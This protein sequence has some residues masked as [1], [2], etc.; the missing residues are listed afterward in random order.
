MDDCEIRLGLPI[1][2]RMSWTARR[3]TTREEAVAYRLL[4]IFDINLPLVYGEGANA[5]LRLQEEI[6]RRSNDL[7]IL[8]HE[9]LSESHLQHENDAAVCGRLDAGHQDP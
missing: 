4:G 7:S 1:A 5:F 6:F 9:T 3:T 8:W 2:R